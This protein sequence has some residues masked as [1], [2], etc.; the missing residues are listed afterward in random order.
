M[1]VFLIH[2]TRRCNDFIHVKGRDRGKRF[3]S[4][5]QRQSRC[6]ETVVQVRSVIMGNDALCLWWADVS[7][8]S[9]QT[10]VWKSGSNGRETKWQAWIIGCLEFSHLGGTPVLWLSQWNPYV[11]TCKVPSPR[12]LP[13]DSGEVMGRAN[14][15]QPCVIVVCAAMFFN[16]LPRG[17]EVDCKGS[18]GNICCSIIQII[19][20]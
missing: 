12:F 14:D 16:Y 6:R 19:K 7:G 4:S 11:T 1:I 10:G 8:H 15:P 17:W 20:K 3:C 13:G 2:F 5:R 18:A 9:S